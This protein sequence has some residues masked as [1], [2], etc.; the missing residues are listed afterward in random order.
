M[1]P[2]GRERANRATIT[3]TLQTIYSVFTLCSAILMAAHALRCNYMEHMF[4]MYI[5]RRS[6]V[7]NEL[8][9]DKHKTRSCQYLQ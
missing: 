6:N 5:T 3:Y 7:R 9:L 8:P 4:S 1:V 2:S